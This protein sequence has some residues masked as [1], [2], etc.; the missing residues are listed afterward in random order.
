[1]RRQRD[2]LPVASPVRTVEHSDAT[3]RVDRARTGRTRRDAVEIDGV[4][5]RVQAVRDA[6]P[7]LPI[8][9]AAEQPADLDAGVE[10]RGAGRI[11][12]DPGDA[13]RSGVRA[14]GDVW[15]GR[16]ERERLPAQPGVG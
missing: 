15:E 14:D 10:L 4:V 8:V 6:L 12:R 3:D 16:V 11:D 2:V 5:G 13:L 7:A 1:H 9:E